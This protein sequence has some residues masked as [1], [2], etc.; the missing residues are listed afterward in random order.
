MKDFPSVCVARTHL[1]DDSV[2]NA[3]ALQITTD[4]NKNFM[5]VQEQRLVQVGNFEGSDIKCREDRL[6]RMF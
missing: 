4:A 2:V 5:I 3:E 6:Y 1:D